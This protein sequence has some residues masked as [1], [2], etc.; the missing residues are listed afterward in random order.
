MP[1]QPAYNC[2]GISE[3]TGLNCFCEILMHSVGCTVVSSCTRLDQCA[4]SASYNNRG[5]YHHH[6]TLYNNSFPC[7]N[8]NG[9]NHDASP[10]HHHW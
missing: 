6:G 4:C 7:H 5:A 8:H 1:F 2:S 9:S 3:T 10:H